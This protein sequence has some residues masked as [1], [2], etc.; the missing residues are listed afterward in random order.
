MADDRA[1]GPSSTSSEVGDAVHRAAGR[2][3][4]AWLLARGLV[5][6]IDAFGRRAGADLPTEGIGQALAAMSASAERAE[7]AAAEIGDHLDAGVVEDVLRCLHGAFLAEEDSR[8]WVRRLAQVAVGV[9]TYDD[10]H[11]GRGRLERACGDLIGGAPGHWSGLADDGIWLAG[12]SVVDLRFDLAGLIRRLMIDGGGSVAIG[13]GPVE[14]IVTHGSGG[15]LI[16]DGNALPTAQIWDEPVT[17]RDVIEVVEALVDLVAAEI[18]DGN[19]TDP[20]QPDDG[21]ISI[22][23]ITASS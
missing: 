4:M 15:R 12:R 8:L 23:V 17:R 21:Y 18:G 9:S 20:P 7:T 13:V 3:T 2:A 16:L 11:P 1:G 22:R 14:A 19:D 5:G 10:D 6:E